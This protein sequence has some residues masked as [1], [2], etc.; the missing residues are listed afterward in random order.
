MMRRVLAVCG[1][2]ALAAAGASGCASSNRCFA[3][4]RTERVAY[5]PVYVSESTCQSDPN[6]VGPR[7]PDGPAGMEGERGATGPTGAPGFAMAGPRGEAGPSGPAGVEGPTGETGAVGAVVRG[8]AGEQGPPGARGEQGAFGLAGAQGDSAAG[9]AGPAGPQGPIGPQG[10]I[11]GTGVRGATV[12]G[13]T[14]PAGHA[15]PTGARGATGYAGAKGGTTAGLAGAAG[16]SGARGP[17]GPTGETGAPG[18][19]ATLGCWTTYR[20]F[21]FESDSAEITVS[22]RNKLT[23]IAVYMRQNP[24]VRIGIDGSMDPRGTDPRNQNLSDRRARAVRDA[25]VEAGVPSHRIS[26]G[27]YAGPENRRDRRVEVLV[28]TAD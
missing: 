10:D 19:V 16:P 15:G 27:A 24:T 18:P 5:A 21:W 22:E 3:K 7:G 14:G 13:P 6:M 26:V 1:I 8:R 2:T 28:A 20:D 25:L 4:T 11:G 9:F 23:E 17:K 12:E